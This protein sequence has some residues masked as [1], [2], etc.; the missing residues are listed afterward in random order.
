MIETEHQPVATNGGRER[1]R[2]ADAIRF[3]RENARDML[4]DGK[5]SAKR[6]ACVDGRIVENDNRFTAPGGALGIKYAVIGGLQAYEKKHGSVG[7]EFDRLSKAIESVFGGMSFHTDTHA[8]HNGKTRISAGCGHC[9][10]ALEMAEEYGLEHYSHLLEAHIDELK[11]RGISPEILS[12]S[13]N[14]KAVFVIAQSIDGKSLALSG[15]GQ[16]GWQAFICHLEDWLEVVASLACKVVECASVEVNEVRL[17]K[18][19]KAAAK[20]QLGVTLR[21]LAEGLPVYCVSRNEDGIIS[22][23]LMTEDAATAFV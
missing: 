3:V 4:S 15:T 9:N 20:R 5:F 14:E 2:L 21:R 18:Y 22:V 17:C 19:I 1:M 13:H 11:D 7:I 8:I 6:W 23:E 16:D 12:G 10:G